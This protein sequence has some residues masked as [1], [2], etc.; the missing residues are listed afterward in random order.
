[1]AKT[2]IL[3]DDDQDDLDILK[4][5]L[6]SIDPSLRYIS[7]IYPLE[8]IRVITNELIMIPDYIITDINMPGMTGDQLVKEFRQHEEFNK[9]VIAVFSTAMSEDLANRLKSLGANFTLKKPNSIDAFKPLLEP[10]FEQERI[11]SNN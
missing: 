5:A 9:T 8:A 7:F 2:V 4:E 3:I 11:R 6:S 10:I 1:M